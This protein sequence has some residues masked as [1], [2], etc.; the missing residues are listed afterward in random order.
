MPITQSA[1]KAYRQS[2]R[3]AERNL[4]RKDAYKKAVKELRGFVSDKKVDAAKEFLPKAFKAL[5]KAAKAGVIEKNKASRLK[6][7]LAKLVK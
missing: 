6:S 3:R 5:D 7:Q 2:L 4:V 1:K